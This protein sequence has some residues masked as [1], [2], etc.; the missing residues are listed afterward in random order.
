MH[1][2]A[3]NIHTRA[4]AE[5]QL[6]TQAYIQTNTNPRAYSPNSTNTRGTTADTSLCTRARTLARCIAC[7]PT[8]RC[9]ATSHSASEVRW[10]AVLYVCVLVCLFV[11]LRP[12]RTCVVCVCASVCA[13]ESV[14]ATHICSASPHR[15]AFRLAGRP[16]SK[17]SGYDCSHLR[18]HVVTSHSV[19]HNFS[20]LHGPF[21]LL[22][23]GTN[24][25]A[26]H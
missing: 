3:R 17:L 5:R 11:F 18:M 26:G 22:G 25:Q 9:A 10:C 15:C 4:H 19:S 12:P 13:R 14:C 21:F 20:S 23:R 6:H 7:S 8:A 16:H 2:I 1:V 24:E